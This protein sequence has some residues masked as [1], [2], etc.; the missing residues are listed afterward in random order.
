MDPQLRRLLLPPNKIQVQTMMPKPIAALY[1]SP[2]SIYKKMPGVDAWDE[3]RDATKWPGG[4]PAILHPPCGQWGRLRQQSRA[5]PTQ[6]ALALVAVEQVRK[7]GGVLEHPT[8]SSLWKEAGLPLP[9]FTD[10]QGGFTIQVDQLHW[11]HAAIKSTWLYIVGTA[12]RDIPPPALSLQPPQKTVPDLSKTAR[13]ATPS[14]FAEWLAAI[15]RT[16]FVPR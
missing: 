9:N 14:G 15:A 4:T 8:G 12:R 10:S 11:G 16:C 1:V 6:K 7:W 2:R 5:C 3:A 13:A